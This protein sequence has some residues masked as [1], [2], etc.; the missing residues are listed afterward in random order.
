MPDIKSGFKQELSSE[1]VHLYRYAFSL[2]GNRAD[3]EDLV[4]SAIEKALANRDRF[5]P[6]TN[7]RGW[8][9][10]IMK[11]LHIDERRK[12]GRRGHSVPLEVWYHEVCYP[13]VQE[14]RVEIKEV[15]ARLCRLRREDQQVVM[16]SAFS[17]LRHQQ[18]A[19][20]LNIAVGTVKSRLCRAR[21]ILA[22]S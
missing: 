19:D 4:H 1:T 7:L 14:S 2:V 22:A 17:D 16:L 18:I 6:G 3:A 15:S 12:I 13:P 20:K 21:R 10:T 9:F 8:L 5:S 11:N